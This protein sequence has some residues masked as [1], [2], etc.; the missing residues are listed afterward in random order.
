MEEFTFNQKDQNIILKSPIALP[1]TVKSL[2]KIVPFIKTPMTV[3]REVLWAKG[4]QFEDTPFDKWL[5]WI[6]N[7]NDPKT[8]PWRTL[9]LTLSQ[10]EC[11][12][13]RT[14]AKKITSKLQSFNLASE[15]I[16]YVIL[17]QKILINLIKLATLKIRYQMAYIFHSYLL[18]ISWHKSPRV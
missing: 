2:L 10:D 16:L 5:Y 7:N 11:C 6:R 9:I 8:E 12:L 4:S 3:E 17:H 18:V 15:I 14:T 13:F 1:L